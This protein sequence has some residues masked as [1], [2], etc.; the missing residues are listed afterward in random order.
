M[1][2]K[3][4]K[5]SA[6]HTQAKYRQ[7][8]QSVINSIAD[9]VI[10]KG[11]KVPSINEI[12]NEYNL[13][14]DTVMLAFNELKARG[15]LGAV[16]GKGYFVESDNIGIEK[17]VLLLFD[18]LNTFKEELYNSFLESMSSDTQVDIYF[19]HFDIHVFSSLI[20]ERVGKYSAYVIMPANLSGILPMVQLLPQDKVYILDRKVDEL[21]GYPVIYQSFDEDMYNGLNAGY[22]LLTKYH[23]MILAYPGGKEPEG[24]LIGFKRFCEDKNLDYD[25]YD[26]IKGRP[27]KKGEVYIL[28]SDRNLINLVKRCWEKGW[29]LGEDVGVISINESALKEVVANGISTIS[30]D[31]KQMGKTLADFVE[32]KK[33]GEVKNI[34]KFTQRNSL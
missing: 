11:D 31:F 34:S 18:E 8:I 25:V 23:K 21:V 32:N 13:S 3:I 19:H 6:A 20:K 27:I 9:G 28:P 10:K 14:R 24:F 26:Q 1:V 15:I 7:I 33:T 16:P 2:K 29:K 30:T 12:A 22:E 17:R 5:I 4:I